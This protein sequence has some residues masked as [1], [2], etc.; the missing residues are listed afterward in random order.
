MNGMMAQA[1]R[2][3]EAGRRPGG[4][5][6]ATNAG[7]VWNQAG[8]LSIDVEL[9]ISGRKL[10]F[11]KVGGDP[12]LALAVRPQESMRWGISLIWSA[13]WIVLGAT[14]LATLRHETAVRR[15][16]RRLPMVAAIFGV[17]GFCVL[18]GSLSICSFVVFVFAALIV[19]FRKQPSSA[20]V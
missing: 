13:V 11:T 10:V 7:P 14:V 2:G 20:T 3:I 8:G 6:M 15:L 16:T 18:P 19:A 12:K 1:G 4:P 5:Q 17:L 9:P